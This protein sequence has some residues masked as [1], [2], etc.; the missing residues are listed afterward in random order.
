MIKRV[1]LPNEAC[2]LCFVN[3]GA[4]SFSEG[5]CCGPGHLQ[6]FK[7]K[8]EAARHRCQFARDV[9]ICFPHALEPWLKPVLKHLH[10]PGFLAT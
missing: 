7:T 9:E 10:A 3:V 1:V 2:T 6:A 5:L 4:L 8:I